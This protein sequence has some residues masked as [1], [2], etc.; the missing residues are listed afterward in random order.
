ML[1]LPAAPMSIKEI[2]RKSFALAHGC[3]PCLYLPYFL[4]L[5]VFIPFLTY[6]DNTGNQ[7]S[8]S[9]QALVMLLM[10]LAMQVCFIF[11]SGFFLRQLYASV[12]GGAETF[13][14][15]ARAVCSRFLAL[16][17]A[18]ILYAL[19]LV[20]GFICLIIPGIYLSLPLFFFMPLILFDNHS[21]VAAITSSIK[22]TWGNWWRTAAVMLIPTL[23]M[24]ILSLITI[25][26]MVI[27]EFFFNV[28]LSQGTLWTYLLD[29]GISLLNAY[30]GL[31]TLS[32]VLL[33]W[34]DLKLRKITSVAAI[35]LESVKP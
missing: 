11:F 32:F 21:P 16:V 6:I 5:I 22:L 17:G 30:V 33:Q 15:S 4:S 35:N 19:L 2:C 24:F 26:F 8:T 18:A 12:Q 27:T 3:L 34:H 20:A 29:L 28:K 23:A 7:H 13:K 1:A 9:L 31:L 14:Q 25:V 10:V